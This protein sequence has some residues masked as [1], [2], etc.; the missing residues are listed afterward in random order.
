MF[1]LAVSIFFAW[2]YFVTYVIYILS[3]NLVGMCGQPS[4]IYSADYM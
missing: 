3:R 4:S 2:H 1:L